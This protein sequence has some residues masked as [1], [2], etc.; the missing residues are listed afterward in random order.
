MQDESATFR[1]YLQ[2]LPDELLASVTEDYIWLASLDFR[3]EAGR[4]A[5]FRRRREC[6]LEECSRRGV[7]QLYREGTAGA[8]PQDAIHVGEIVRPGAEPA[9]WP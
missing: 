7:R 5:E 8:L 3:E 4:D 9:V 1:R 6:C 2:T